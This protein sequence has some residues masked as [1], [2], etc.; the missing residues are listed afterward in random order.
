MAEENNNENITVPNVNLTG[1]EGY[2]GIFDIDKTLGLGA[3]AIQA[4]SIDNTAIDEYIST[5]ETP[6]SGSALDKVAAMYRSQSLGAVLRVKKNVTNLIGP[7][8]NLIKEREAAF[9]A[10]FAILQQ[11]LPDI[12]NSVIFGDNDGTPIPITD[13]IVFRASQVRENMRLLA[14]LNP[15]DERYANLQKKIEKNQ[16]VVVNFDVVNKRLLEIRNGEQVPESDFGKDMTDEE[17]AMWLDIYNE[18]GENIKINEDGRLIWQDPNNPDTPPIY[19]DKIAAEP[20]QNLGVPQD[21]DVLIRGEALD[22]RNALERN[23]AGSAANSIGSEVYNVKMLPLFAKMTKLKPDQI[24]SLVWNGFGANEFYDGINTDSFVSSLIANQIIY[25]S[26]FNEKYGGEDGVIDVENITPEEN[27]A[28]I[29]D[30]KRDGTIKEYYDAE[31]NLV[32]MKTQFLKWYKSTVN[33][34]ITDTTYTAP[35]SQDNRVTSTTTNNQD[36]GSGDDRVIIYD[37]DDDEDDDGGGD[38][39][40]SIVIPSDDPNRDMLALNNVDQTSNNISQGDPIIASILQDQ[41]IDVDMYDALGNFKGAPTD[42]PNLTAST[43]ESVGFNDVIA[44][45]K[46]VSNYLE[47]GKTLQFSKLPK[48]RGIARNVMASII[49]KDLATEYI[50]K[51]GDLFKAE[52]MDFALNKYGEIMQTTDGVNWTKAPFNN[53]NIAY[54]LVIDHLVNNNRLKNPVYREIL[55]V[56]NFN[57]YASNF[58]KISSGE[59]KTANI[60]MN[61]DTIYLDFDKETKLPKKRATARNITF[62]FEDGQGFIQYFP[63]NEKYDKLMP[64]LP[65]DPEEIINMYKRLFPKAKEKDI[66]AFVNEQIKNSIEREKEKEK[67]N[68]EKDKKE[69]DTKKMSEDLNK[70]LDNLLVPYAVVGGRKLEFNKYLLQ[71]DDNKFVINS[72]NREFKKYGFHFFNTTKNR[73]AT[74][75]TDMDTLVFFHE[76]DPKTAVY[77]RFDT[78]GSDKT[79]TE[80]MIKIMKKMYENRDKSRRDYNNTIVDFTLP[81]PGVDFESDFNPFDDK[82]VY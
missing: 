66:K 23:Q 55:P 37:F 48:S 69:L 78:M 71:Y 8:V 20:K 42:D 65:Y 79:N 10:R 43:D 51:D 70:R 75:F 81:M 4:R 5:I 67:E 53:N 13:D 45:F 49:G 12:S 27:A 38:D 21:V 44:P 77:F 15:A 73:T 28:I 52:K 18:K 22:F 80:K 17:K 26:E 76:T 61:P 56:G 14:A 31:G 58:N 68:K 29:N 2:K 30:M 24:N 60:K 57:D 6:A 25:N 3:A 46:A 82:H 72:L 74:S 33:G 63:D 40:G 34:I 62:T 50:G 41:G 59:S 9:K 19:L 16:D 7:T 11:S 36:G 35:V 32:S 1:P 39:S 47:T 64:K 54:N